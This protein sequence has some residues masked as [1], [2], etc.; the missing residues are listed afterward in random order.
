MGCDIHAFLEIKMCKDWKREGDWE[1]PKW[2]LFSELDICRNYTLFG[3]M[4]GV[5][6]DE[7]EPIAEPRGLPDDLSDVVAPLAENSYE[8]CH[9][10]SWLSEKELQDVVVWFHEYLTEFRK[11]RE[12]MRYSVYDNFGY[13]LGVDDFPDCMGVMEV[14]LVFWFD[15]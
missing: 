10:H 12:N 9:S 5:R 14:R 8:W 13:R 11:K 4:A 3:K 1:P 6:N 2:Y 7:V 15:N